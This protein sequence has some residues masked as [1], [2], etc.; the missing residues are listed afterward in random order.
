[1]L[2]FDESSDLPVQHE[3][4]RVLEFPV[5]PAEDLDSGPK[6]H[7]GAII[8]SF[9]LKRL[10]GHGGMGAVYLGEH[11]EIGKRVAIKIL[12]PGVSSD[13]DSVARFLREARLVTKL[14]HPAIVDVHDCGFLPGV[15]RYLVMEYLEG[16]DLRSYLKKQGALSPY[17]ATWLAYRVAGALEVAHEAGII[18]RDLKPANI[19]LARWGKRTGVK[20]LDFGVAKLLGGA[21]ESGLTTS[22]GAVIGTPAYMAPEQATGHGLDYRT[23]IY[24]LG[25]ILYEMVTGRRPFAG[26]RPG[27][28]LVLQQ[29]EMPPAPSIFTPDFPEALEV[30]MM[31]CLERLPAKRPQSARELREELRQLLLMLSQPAAPK[32]STARGGSDGMP[33]SE[34]EFKPTPR[35]V[36]IRSY[37]EI[38]ALPMPKEAGHSQLELKAIP[39]PKSQPRLELAALRALATVEGIPQLAGSLVQRNEKLPWALAFV[40]CMLVSFLAACLLR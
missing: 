2:V 30:F 14:S 40:S 32:T 13:P 31:R 33:Q 24:S 16:C 19:F 4:Q 18:H 22:T 25:V 5:L 36:A 39:T 11:T 35:G 12:K 3:S 8:G 29:M 27:E 20:L 17:E 38:P 28:L 9:R 37:L 23:D 1:M 21:E 10:L 26:K 6:D 34:A 7:V 15:G